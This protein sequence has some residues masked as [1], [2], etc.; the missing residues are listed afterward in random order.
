MSLQATEATLVTLDKGGDVLKEENI[1]IDLVQ[2]GDMLR[3]SGG[4]SGSACSRGSGGRGSGGRVSEGR[5][6]GGR[7]SSDTD[8]VN[9]AGDSGVSSNDDDDIG[10]LRVVV[11]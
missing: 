11:N 3:V 7:G 5:G 8:C 2:R 9:D 1:S 6:C 4:G 10:S